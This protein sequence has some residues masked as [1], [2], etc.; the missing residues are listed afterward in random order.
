MGK[1]VGAKGL[2]WVKIKE[3]AFEG[4]ISKFLKPEEQKAIMEKMGAKDN[5][6]LLF[7]ADTQAVADRTLGELRLYLANKMDIIPADIFRGCWVVDFPAF[8][9]DEE[10]KRFVAVHH[11]FTSPK[12][13]DADKLETAPGEVLAE[14]YD[15]VVNGQ[16]LGG[17]SVRIHD[18]AVQKKVFELLGI[19]EEEA[20]AKFSFLLDAL[21]YGAPPHAG[22]AFGF[23]RLCML[24]TGKDAIQD[25]VAFPKTQKG[26]CPL[27][28]APGVVDK[29]QLGE[30]FLETTVPEKE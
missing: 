15:I 16:E 21:K 23:D 1:T 22:I 24:V 7:I 2:A 13:G 18:Q 12:A 20:D 28:N 11:P 4:G 3:G 8:D 6:M 10:E 30:L 19:S 25:V 29:K 27:T 5:D 14:A 17:G 9:W 26:V